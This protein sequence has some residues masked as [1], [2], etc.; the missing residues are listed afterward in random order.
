MG[1]TP[2]ILPIPFRD[3]LEAFAPFAADPTCALLDSAAQG[4]FSILAVDPFDVLTSEGRSD[5]LGDLAEALARHRLKPGLHPFPFLTGAIG[6][7]GYE[8]GG[9][10]ERLPAPRPDGPHMPE[11]HLGLYDTA[12][13][14]D[15]TERRAWVVASGRQADH[16][17]AWLAKKIAAAPALPPLSDIAYG[18]WRAEQSR[19]S[20]QAQVAQIIE[21]IRAGEVF[22]VNLSQRFLADAPSG[23][24]PFDLYRRLRRV[25]PAPFGAYLAAGEVGWVL[26]ASPERFLSLNAQGRVETRPIKGTRA[27]SSDPAVDQAQA[28]ALLLSAKDRAE[29]LMIVDLLRNDLSRVCQLGSVKAPVVCGLESFETV[30]HLVSVVEGQLRPKLGA[31]DLLKAAFPGGSVTG[32]PKIR[33]MEIIHT[34]EKTRRGPYCGAVGW[35]GFDG[36]MDSSI[37]IRS[38]VWSG[39][40]IIAQAGGGVVSDS[41]PSA[42]YEETLTKVRPLLRALDSAGDT[43]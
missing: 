27:R 15:E 43:P 19:D 37:V 26:S 5:P 16:K 24:T 35:I 39:K 1:N 20:Y 9:T 11:M 30:H 3:P 42:E 38:L 13:V 33:A 18:P 36:A 40:Q 21:A 17:A 10:L 22:Q 6:Y 34:L 32:A 29:N 12:A 2:F 14:F 23:L 41:D 7:F 28:E 8:L 25:N 31:V 4:R